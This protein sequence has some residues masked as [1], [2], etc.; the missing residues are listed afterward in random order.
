M[1]S[2]EQQWLTLSEDPM[3]R[4]EDPPKPRHGEA[5]L[6]AAVTAL[7]TTAATKLAERAIEHLWPRKDEHK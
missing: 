6:V 5:I 7:V 2:A 1:A 3:M 4:A